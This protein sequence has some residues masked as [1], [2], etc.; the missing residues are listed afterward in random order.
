MIDKIN[1]NAR[2]NNNYVKG[3][4]IVLVVVAMGLAGWLWLGNQQAPTLGDV[5][6]NKMGNR[7]AD[8]S[9]LVAS[10]LALSLAGITLTRGYE[11]LK[12]KTSAP[13]APLTQAPP[14]ADNSGLVVG[15]KSDLKELGR[16]KEW[17]QQENVSLKER[18]ANLTSE[19]DEMSRAEK[20]LRKSN[21]SLS[22]E[23]ERLKSENE[24]LLLKVNALKM[25]PKKGK[26]RA[27]AKTKKRN[28]SKAKK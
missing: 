12:R 11:I 27:R 18:I 21:I 3:T 23:C 24:M 16:V 26:A 8:F 22:K 6:S 7:S 17:L 5:L 28:K 25:K 4:F 15:L 19:T 1:I 9:M 14:A 10:L 2:L 13:K 20:M